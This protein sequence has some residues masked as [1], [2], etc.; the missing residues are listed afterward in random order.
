[1]QGPNLP[2]S[3]RFPIEGHCVIFTPFWFCDRT[4]LGL[5]ISES[6]R[7]CCWCLLAFMLAVAVSLLVSL[8]SQHTHTYYIFTHKRE[9]ST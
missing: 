4:G 3:A 5:T 2:L 7:V 6:T 9:R 8:M 1:M